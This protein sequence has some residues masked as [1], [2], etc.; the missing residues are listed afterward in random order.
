MSETQKQ[1]TLA[2][3]S[4][5]TLGHIDHGKSTTMGRFLYE[6]GAVDQRTI[7]RLES[8]SQELKRSSWKWAFV[9]DST[10]EERTGGITADIAFQPFT[11]DEKPYMLIDAPGHRDFVKNAIRGAVL[12]DACM[13]LVS[14]VPNDLRSGLKQ[15]SGLADPGGQT[16]EHC[17]LG[18]VLGINQVIF[19]INKMD[20]VNYS[21]QSYKEAVK[22]ISAFLKE[23]QSPWL[24]ILNGESFIPISGL[25]GDNLVKKSTKMDWWNGPTVKE[26]LNKFNPVNKNINHTRFL[27]HDSFEM[28]GIGTVLHGRL[29]SGTMSSSQKVVYLP[30]N[31]E[32]EIK[33]LWNENG[34]QINSLQAGE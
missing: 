25:E 15:G 33:D 10:E 13:V 9:L 24:K 23:I 19:L 16:R 5:I 4:L 1:E 2:M 18:S 20:A 26:A 11:I 17:I 7:D 34:E 30:N 12:A 28:P 22:I 29:I 3:T 21:E 32:T 31:I 27:T 14:A 8:E 6:I